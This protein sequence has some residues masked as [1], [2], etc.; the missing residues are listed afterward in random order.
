MLEALASAFPTFVQKVNGNKRVSVE[1]VLRPTSD[2]EIRKIEAELGVPLPESYKAFLRAVRGLWL[3][4]GAVQFGAG[5][6][7]LHDFP[8]LGELTPAQRRVVEA[9][10]GIWP[11]PSQGMLCFAEYFLEADGDQVLFDV[12][13]GLVDGE[14]PVVYYSHESRP[15]GV[16]TI[17][18]SFADWLNDHCLD[19]MGT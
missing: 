18:A 2:A 14:Y 19:E 6:P 4:G 13:Q 1:H 10:G 3:F 12:A 17:S 16:R 8:A 15:P 11:P 7:F 5:H 9:K